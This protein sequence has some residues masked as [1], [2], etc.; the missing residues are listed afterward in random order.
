V[1]DLQQYLEDR[2]HMQ[3]QVRMHLQRAQERMKKQADRGR[4]ERQ[5]SVGDS[6]LK[7]QHV[8]T[9]NCRFVSLGLT[10]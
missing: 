1:P 2:Q 6:F 3:Q 10:Q 7:L 5:F 9:K 8:S 4:T